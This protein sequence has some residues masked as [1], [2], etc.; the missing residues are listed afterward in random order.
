M[1]LDW[2]EVGVPPAE[3]LLPVLMTYYATEYVI[4]GAESKPVLVIPCELVRHRLDD[5][6]GTL[7]RS[8]CDHNHG[9][10]GV[11]S[12]ATWLPGQFAGALGGQV[13]G[14]GVAL[15]SFS[16]VQAVSAGR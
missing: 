14:S 12:R 10:F 15:R 8:A 6:L 2:C 13:P 16:G 4:D 7:V 1:F 3:F 11:L 9:V 5:C